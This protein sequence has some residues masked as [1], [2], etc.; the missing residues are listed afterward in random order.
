MSS[1]KGPPPNI[2][3]VFTDQQSA[4]MMSCAGNHYVD[5]PAMDRLAGSGV[6]FERTYCT[7]P[8]CLPSRTSLMTGQ[9]PGEIGVRSNDHSHLE[10][11]PE[12]VTRSG[13]G[14]L[15]EDAGYE[16]VYGGKE[17]LPKMSV[18][19]LG[20]ERLTTD[21]REGLAHACVEYI[22]REHDDPFLL[23][24]SFINPHDIC[25]MAIRDAREQYPVYEDLKDPAAEET[26]DEVLA[27]P[28]DI[29]REAFFEERCPPLPSNH[30]PQDREPKAIRRLIE[31]KGYRTYAREE[32]T[33]E[34]WRLYRWA[35]ARLVERV[36]TQIGRVVNAIKA[37]TDR[38]TI[39]VLTS[40][41]G[42]MDAAH[43]LEHKTVFY[44]EAV[45][46]PLIVSHPGLKGVVDREH[47][48][49]NGV[50]V[51]ATICDYAGVD[52]PD[53]C[54]GRSIRPLV[55]GREPDDWRDCIR[56][57]SELGEAIV[58][59]RYK[60]ALYDDGTNREQLYDLNEDPGETRNAADDSETEDVVEELH[61][62][63]IDGSNLR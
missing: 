42:D 24:A 41:H 8:V 1:G 46:V 53:N 37:H 48:V 57:E 12:A 54:S 40:D 59:D 61:D 39:V 26:L 36:D 15:L 7:N 47:L 5:T 51:L 6:R 32:W 21:E 45:R 43:R 52:T 63:L 30:A 22:E 23:V 17:H 33:D 35:Y 9:F 62:R 31:R 19:D 14:H 44:E 2:V 60:Y 28:E 56:I 18:E 4:H 50:D 11:I 34:R 58:T 25:Y 29:S 55:E 10:G 27:L 38:E 16:A 3:F 13:L 49:S 20:F